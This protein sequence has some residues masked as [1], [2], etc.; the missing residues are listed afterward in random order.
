MNVL[1][2]YTAVLTFYEFNILLI[3]IFLHSDW[4]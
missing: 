1:M 4:R 3:R 2:K